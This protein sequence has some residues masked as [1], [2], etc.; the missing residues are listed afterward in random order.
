MERVRDSERERE[1]EREREGGRW[2][3]G[4]EL[5]GVPLQFFKMTECDRDSMTVNSI[6]FIFCS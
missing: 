2:R 6:F 5:E 3:E 4:E 1:R